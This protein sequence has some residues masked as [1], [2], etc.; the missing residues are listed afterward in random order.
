[1]GADILAWLRNLWRALKV[2]VMEISK[3]FEQRLADMGGRLPNGK[4]K[5][6]FVF[7]PDAKRAHGTLAGRP[8]YL[9]PDT[10]RPMPWNI[11]EAW[12]PPEMAGPR[13][14]WP[15]DLLG[16]YPADCHEDCCDGGIWGLRTP[17][18][19]TNGEFIP[20]C[21][22]TMHMIERKQFMDVKWSLTDEIT[23]QN[24]LDRALSDRNNQTDRESREEHAHIRDHY[25][26][27]KETL[28][29]A[30]NRVTVG[31]GKNTLPDVKGGKLPIGPPK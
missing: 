28:D 19:N 25:L 3:E 14:T 15:Y 6:R 24:M 20:I 17:I 12:L 7:G 5:L 26:T 13:E 23:R 22:A 1:M 29:N 21:E 16:P 2:L 9:L 27:N 10:G 8:K 4:P 30:D 11:L 18:T 31:F